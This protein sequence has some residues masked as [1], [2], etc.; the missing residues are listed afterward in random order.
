VTSTIAKVLAVLHDNTGGAAFPTMG[1]NGGTIGG[2]NVI[3]SDGVPAATMLL[4]DAQQVAAASETI[5]LSASNEAIVQ[6]DT[7]PDSPIF[8]ST[9][10]VSLWQMNMVGLR[11]ERFFGVQKLTTTGVCVLTGASYTGDSPGP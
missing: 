4:V 7:A 8:A 1:V 10:M 5:Q 6:L 2:I 3:V 9:P 11:A